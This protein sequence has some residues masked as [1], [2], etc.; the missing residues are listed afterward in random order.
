MQFIHDVNVLPEF[1]YPMKNEIEINYLDHESLHLKYN[2]YNGAMST[3]NCDKLTST[4][5]A[6]NQFTGLR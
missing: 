4:I 1:H 5:R 3:L 6:L 2:F